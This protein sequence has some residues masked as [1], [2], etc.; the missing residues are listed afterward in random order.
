LKPSFCTSIQWAAYFA[1]EVAELGLGDLVLAAA[2]AAQLLLD[3]PLDRQ[4]VAVPAGHVVDVVA[5]Q[6][7]RA[8]HEVLQRLLQA[9]ADVDRPVGV[10]RSVMQHEQ[11]RA[12]PLPVGADLVV[13]VGLVPLGQ[14]LRL[15]LRQARA[16]GEGRVGKEDG[17]AVVAS[18]FLGVVGHDSI[19]RVRSGPGTASA[20]CAASLAGMTDST[21]NPARAGATVRRRHA[22]RVI[23]RLVRTENMAGALAEW[24][25]GVIPGLCRDSV[26]TGSAGPMDRA[27]S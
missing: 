15:L 2:L 22:G 18:G 5:Q 20:A 9:V 13:E 3:L 26:R 23:R 24:A 4:A 17:L 21:A 12:R 16:H 6:E 11:R 27:R 25:R 1:A 19:Q 8:D 14:D 7:L 10:G